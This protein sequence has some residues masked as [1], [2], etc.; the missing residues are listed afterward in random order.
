MSALPSLYTLLALLFTAVLLL[1]LW[2]PGLA[3]PVTVWALAA[4][5]PVLAA[6]AAALTG[7][8]RADRVTAGY[9]PVPVTV[10]V[11]ALG[12]TRTLQ[13]TAQDAA[14]L[15][16]ARMNGTDQTLVLPAPEAPLRLPKGAEITGVLPAERIVQA[17][18]VQGRLLCRNLRVATERE[19]E[20][21][22]ALSD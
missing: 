9:L 14:C 11:N 7:Q 22:A 10:T 20:D 18:T 3:R 8:A 12:R 2:R 6:V 17:L 5:L 4:G 21:A 19:K 13:L 15:T 16:R 1:M